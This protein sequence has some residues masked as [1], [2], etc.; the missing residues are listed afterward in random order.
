MQ[1]DTA[2]RRLF[3]AVRPDDCGDSWSD[4]EDSC[5]G[6]SDLGDHAI[7]AIAAR[8]YGPFTKGSKLRARGMVSGARIAINQDCVRSHSDSTL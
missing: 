8:T 7:S 6:E 2:C 4:G 1:F 3:T 5:D